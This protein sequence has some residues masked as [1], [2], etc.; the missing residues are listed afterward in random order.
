MSINKNK[1]ESLKNNKYGKVILGNNAPT[2]VLGKGRAKLDQYTKVVDALLVQGIKQ[3]ILCV[4]QIANN[5]HIIMFT[6]AKCK[7]I[8]EDIGKVIVRGLKNTDKLY[9]LVKNNSGKNKRYSSS[10]LDS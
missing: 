4:G 1:F 8:E 6:S 9:V 5:G 2:K 7:V 3:N 10:S